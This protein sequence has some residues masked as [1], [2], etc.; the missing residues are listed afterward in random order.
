MA[1][2]S[3][4]MDA[5]AHD[6][7]SSDTVKLPVGLAGPLRINGLCAHGDFYLPLATTEAALVA[8]YSRGCQTIT[9]A[10][11]CFTD[12]SGK[13]APDGGDV[14]CSNGQLHDEVLSLLA[15]APRLGQP[16]HAPG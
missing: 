15:G 3:H 8:S 2:T 1:R 5:P 16:D 6:T 13:P 4:G 12:L 11:G 14:L 10:G 9:E 7:A